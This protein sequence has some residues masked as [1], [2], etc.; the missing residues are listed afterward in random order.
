MGSANDSNDEE[1][2][3]RAIKQ[4]VGA[5]DHV[6]AGGDHGGGVDESGDGGGAFHCVG[7]PDVEGKLRALAC[8]AE[9]ETQGSGGED[10]TGPC[11]ICGKSCGDFAEGKRAEIRKQ[12]KHAD[13]ETEVANPV[14]DESFF[15]RVGSR[16]F[17]IVEADKKIGCEVRR[18][19]I[20]QT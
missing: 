16:C 4:R 2:K 13:E 8:S 1:C 18:P 6:D 20:Q 12:E 7:Q 10:A 3:G 5:G 19:P 11:R 15:A 9:K 14:N 17:L